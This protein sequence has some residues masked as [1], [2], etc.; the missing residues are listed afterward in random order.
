MVSTQQCQKVLVEVHIYNLHLLSLPR[1]CRYIIPFPRRLNSMDLPRL[2]D[3]NRLVERVESTRLVFRVF[4]NYSHRPYNSNTGFIAHADYPLDL[5]DATAVERSVEKHLHFGN[6]EATPWIST[7]RRWLWAVWE[8]NRRANLR[9]VPR[10]NIKIAVVNLGMCL[11]ANRRTPVLALGYNDLPFIHALSGLSKEVKSLRLRRFADVSDEILIYHQIPA[12]AVIS[13]W[14]LDGVW[15]LPRQFTDPL[16]PLNP[17]PG[18]PP[19]FR[20]IHRAVSHK[21]LNDKKNGKWNAG[22]A[23]ILCSIVA[24][25]LLQDAYTRLV[26]SVEGIV[27]R[28]RRINTWDEA[29][30]RTFRLRTSE[31]RC[32]HSYPF[33]RADVISMVH[34]IMNEIVQ[35]PDPFCR[36]AVEPIVAR[37]L[38]FS[39]QIGTT[40]KQLYKGFRVHKAAF[41]DQVMSVINNSALVVQARHVRHKLGGFISHALEMARTVPLG[42]M[43]KLDITPSEWMTMKRFIFQTIQS[44]TTPLENKLLPLVNAPWEGTIFDHRGR[45]EPDVVEAK[46]RKW[47]RRELVYPIWWEES[48]M[49]RD[50]WDY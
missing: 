30:P 45:T 39:Y 43:D 44:K 26:D 32:T 25:A 14:A 49:Q 47:M 11:E 31:P 1:L 17:M 18:W 19:D 33:S 29:S 12:S 23:G 13:I 20:S 50:A 4:D 46:K 28:A 35:L 16:P 42:L 40:S 5:S 15:A 21:F 27:H 2:K 9:K 8:A 38:R 36:E 41:M 3:A 22:E 7:T 48:G 37:E 24:L 10:S 34:S 6:P